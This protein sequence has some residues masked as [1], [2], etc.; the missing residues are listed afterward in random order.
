MY[1]RA[2]KC[3]NMQ[4]DPS[5]FVLYLFSLRLAFDVRPN[6]EVNDYCAGQNLAI[7]LK[8]KPMESNNAS[9]PYF[10]HFA[11]SLVSLVHIGV[12]VG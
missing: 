2:E 1:S 7:M 9:G 8:W 5:F 6:M 10:N 3:Q 11:S 4:T 12:Y